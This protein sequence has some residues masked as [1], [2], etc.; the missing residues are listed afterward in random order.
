MEDDEDDQQFFR[1]AIND[2][3]NTILLKFAVNG[4]DALSKL[5]SM[6]VLPDLIFMDINMPKMNGL[7]CLN[8]LK[9]SARFKNIPVVVLTTS[10]NARES[11]TAF[12]YNASA[13]IT[14]PSNAAAL[15]KNITDMLNIYTSLPVKEFDQ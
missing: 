10:L 14:K 15:K 9:N 5:G 2:I 12:A 11:K 8:R 3:D 13:F 6:I 7:E 4:V 1:E